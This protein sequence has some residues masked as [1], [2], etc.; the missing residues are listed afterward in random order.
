MRWLLCL[1]VLMIG[2]ASHG[3]SAPVPKKRPPDPNGYGYLGVSLQGLTISEIVPNT[4]ASGS[5]LQVDDEITKIGTNEVKERDEAIH[6]IATYRPGATISIEV[7]RGTEKLVVKVTLD[8][9]PSDL[10][11]PKKE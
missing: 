4:P 1:T 6:M 8:A 9:R 5:T 11:L 10:P 7:K 3:T 2:L